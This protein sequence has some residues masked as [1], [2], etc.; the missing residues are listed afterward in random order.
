M[1]TR[2]LLADLILQY[3]LRGF[4][5]WKTST[6]EEVQRRA[7]ACLKNKIFENDGE[8]R[9]GISTL[10][11]SKF[12][13]MPKYGYRTNIE[14]CFFLPKKSKT[15]GAEIW[16][17][18]LYIL[19]SGST[20]LAFRFEPA[21]DDGSRHNYAHMQFC[22]QVMGDDSDPIGIPS[23]LPERDP[24]FPLPSSDP[25][26]LFLAM[27]IS[28]H[29]R[30]GGIEQIITAIFQEANQAHRTKKYFDALKGMLDR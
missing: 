8:L 2:D 11:E 13:P 24:A 21:G 10:A 1:A 27:L 15:A 22:R 28:V 17:F 20:G 14:Q 18:V 19:I 16:M 23:W 9:Y 4:G 12:V 3:A 6:P 30:K 5:D 29:G 25:L 26:M 7:R